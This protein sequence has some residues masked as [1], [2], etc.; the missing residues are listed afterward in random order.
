MTFEQINSKNHLYEAILVAFLDDN[1]LLNK[2]H[3]HSGTL[4]E[5]VNDTYLKIIDADNMYPLEWYIIHDGLQTIGYCVISKTYSFIYSFGINIYYRTSENMFDWFEEVKELFDGG[6]TCGLW[7]KNDRAI[8]YLVRNGMSVY[9]KTDLEI[10]L[11][12][13]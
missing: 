8:D 10:H 9:D 2:Y 7:T 12:Y 5:C 1:L 4:V 13:N 11:K 3:I 6:F